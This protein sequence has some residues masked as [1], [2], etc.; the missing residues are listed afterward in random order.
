MSYEYK[1]VGAPEEPRRQRGVRAWSDR[2]AL[3]MQEVIA[4]EAVD[5]WEYLRTDIL[6]VEEKDGLFSRVRRIK[7][8]V[9]IFRRELGDAPRRHAAEHQG[10]IQG[11]TPGAILADD[12]SP[13]PS[14]GQK[15]PG[16]QLSAERSIPAPPSQRNRLSPADSG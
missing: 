11:T 8:A 7:R 12:S 3:A 10:S 5:G 9:L 4:A 15:Q 16:I 14:A 1:C 6:P 13:R 2:V